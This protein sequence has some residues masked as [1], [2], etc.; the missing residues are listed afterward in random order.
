MVNGIYFGYDLLFA[1]TMV[2]FFRVG[3]EECSIMFLWTYLFAA[4]GLAVW[5]M[6]YIWILVI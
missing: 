6:I 5:S 4:I 3:Q 2:E 1:G